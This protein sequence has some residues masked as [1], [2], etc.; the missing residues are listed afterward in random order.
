MTVAETKNVIL[1]YTGFT[2]VFLHVIEI[3]HRFISYVVYDSEIE[4]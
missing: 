1:F 4:D 2:A 3:N